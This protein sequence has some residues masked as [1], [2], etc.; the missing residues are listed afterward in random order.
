MY[1]GWIK[2]YRKG[3]QNPLFKRPL[4]W[5]FW[6]YCRLRANHEDYVMDFNGKPFEVK[7]GCFVTSLKTIK[8]ET[9]LSE[10]NIRT[11]I[12]ILSAHK[13]ILKSTQ[14][15]TKQATLIEVLNY[16]YYQS[17]HSVDN[18]VDNEV[19]TESQ[20]SSNEELTTNNNVKKPNNVKSSLAPEP[21]NYQIPETLINWSKKKDISTDRLSGY[22]KACLIWHASKGNKYVKW[23]KVIQTWINKDLSGKYNRN[24]KTGKTFQVDYNG[25]EYKS[26]LV[27]ISNLDF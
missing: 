18:E 10:Q 19:L 1:R 23:D 17:Y 26:G 6:V 13:M 14:L 5:H 15:L 27:D 21:E 11:A 22:I 2:D 9:G 8:D 3:L 4:I 7:R 12:K 24:R 20:Q 25:P 16:D